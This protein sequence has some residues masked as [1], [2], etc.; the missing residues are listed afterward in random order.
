MSWAAHLAGLN[1]AVVSALSDGLARYTGPQG[2]QESAEFSVIIERNLERVGP[3]GVFITD[4]VG[5]GWNK[6]DQPLA[7]RGGILRIGSEHFVI[8][9]PLSDDG[10]HVFVACMSAP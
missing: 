7:A 4:A 6:A 2:G 8:E 1:A 9:E 5:I 10:S 3:E